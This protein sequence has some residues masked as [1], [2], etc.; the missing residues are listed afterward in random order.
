[1]DKM[2]LLSCDVD[3]YGLLEFENQDLMTISEVQT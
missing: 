2:T 3:P 1:M